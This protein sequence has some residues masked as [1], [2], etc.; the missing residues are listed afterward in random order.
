MEYTLCSQTSCFV[1]WQSE[2][3]GHRSKNICVQGSPEST[4]CLMA[5][6]QLVEGMILLDI[7]LCLS[8][9]AYLDGAL[10]TRLH[11]YAPPVR[12]LQIH[13]LSLA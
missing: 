8:R 6:T 2:Y 12:E 5:Q 7:R 3:L 13:S 1:K 10:S 4:V 11:K 9:L